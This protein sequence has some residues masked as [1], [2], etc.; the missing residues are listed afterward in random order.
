MNKNIINYQEVIFF[1]HKYEIDE[2]MG[3]LNSIAPKKNP[4]VIARVNEQII[5]TLQVSKASLQSLNKETMNLSYAVDD[6]VSILERTIQNIG[7]S[8]D[9]MDE[10]ISFEAPLFSKNHYKIKESDYGRF[11]NGR[12][13]IIESINSLPDSINALSS[14]SENH[15]GKLEETNELKHYVDYLSKSNEIFLELVNAYNPNL[16]NSL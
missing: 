1:S 4:K 13:Q 8:L 3:I 12:N 6:S 14:N 11:E 9:D 10:V 5:K 15:S 7:Y 2:L 16:F